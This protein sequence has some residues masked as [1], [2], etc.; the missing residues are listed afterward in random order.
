MIFRRVVLILLIAQM[1][2]SQGGGAGSIHGVV[3]NDYSGNPYVEASVELL[4]VQRGRVFSRI[5]RT[6]AKGEFQFTD[7]PAGSGYQIIV[8]GER[9][10]PTAYGQRTWNEPWIPIQVEPGEQVRD[11]RISVQ[12]LAAIRGRVVDSQGK[13]LLGARVVALRPVY[14]TR[15]TLQGSTTAITNS[16]GDYQFLSMPAGVYYLRAFPQSS[17]PAANMVLSTPSR[18]DRSPQSNQSL[19]VKDPEGYPVTYFPSTVNIESAKPID[20]KA[21]GSA[22]NADIVVTRVRTS[23]VRGTVTHEGKP[24]SAG[25][26]LLQRQATAAD[27]SWTRVSEI[28]EGQFEMRGVLPGSYIAWARTGEPEKRLWSRIP[29]EIRPAETNTIAIR[30]SPAPDISGKLSFD[31]ATDSTPDFTQLGVYL[32]PEALM[33]VDFTLQRVELGVPARTVT[34]SADGSF[35]FRGVAPW[36]YRVV[37][38]VPPNAPNAASLGRVYLKSARHKGSDTANDG[39]RVTTEF[40]GSLDLTLALDSGG[41]DGRVLNETKE[42]AG[43]A[44]VVL[45]P[46]ARHRLD[47]YLAVAASATGRF[48]MPGI[49]PGKYKIFAW[50][51]APTGAWYDPDFLQTYED[52]ARPVE[53][54]PGSAEFVELQWML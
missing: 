26:V 19:V 27:S 39:L 2:V 45:I 33:P 50:K 52:R 40:E 16:H 28:T 3:V 25:Q 22:D 38:S 7:V 21:G 53:I 37:V 35:T 48:Q 20:L 1:A 14:Q 23:R 36:D 54:L 46:D 18:V 4:G 51:D 5:V 11:L 47:R 29:V 34:P 24:V 15:R 44:R 49:P 12:P 41:L 32:I 13:G 9:L 8:T 30:V 6:N 17:D 31:G 10:Q 42:S 43:S